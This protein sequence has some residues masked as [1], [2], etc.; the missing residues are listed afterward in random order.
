MLPKFISA[1]LLLV[2]LFG[3]SNYGISYS[4]VN[5]DSVNPKDFIR[6]SGTQLVVGND[7][8]PIV[9]QGVCFGN[10]VWSNPKQP[11]L[12]HHN[13]TDFNSVR[14]LRMNVIRFYLNYGLFEDDTRPFQYKKSGWDWLDRN[15][16][17]AKRNNVYL[18][19]N[20]H[21]PQGGYQ[22][23]GAGAALWD[24]PRNQRRLIALWKAIAKHCQAETIVAG[25][26]LV[27]EPITTRSIGQWQ[28]LAQQLVD[29]IRTVDQNHLLIVERLNAIK[30][31]WGN[32]A[33]YNF[34]LVND[35]NVM[36]TFHF[37]SPIEYTHQLTGWTGFGNQDGGTY[38]DESKYAFP[39]DLTWANATLSNPIAPAGKFNWTFFNG[40]HTPFQVT[41]P[42]IRCA[43]PAFQS[44]KNTGTIYFANFTVKEFD[45]SGNF[46]RYVYQD[47]A[48]NDWNG[49]FWSRNNSGTVRFVPGTGVNERN[50]IAISRT[51]DDANYSLNNLRFPVKTGYYY[52]ISG[53]MKGVDVSADSQCRLRLDFEVS[54]SGGSVFRR[55]KEYLAN[56][57]QHYIDW[58][59]AHRVPL[60]VGEFGAYYVC[61]Q[62]NKGGLQ[63]ISD[64]LDL[65]KANC[66]SYTYHAYHESG[67]G[68]YRNDIGLPDP[69]NVNQPLL[70]LFQNKLAN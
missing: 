14:N 8:H 39:T 58:G 35:L 67:F 33:N 34:C 57:L 66:L 41:D 68:L 6:A 53:W 5:A 48:F 10:Q 28:E 50:S 30:S 16:A 65:Y 45:A 25:Y 69:A 32:D 2:Y 15:I 7:D 42:K 47:E 54:P 55:D 46:V 62:N 21:Y 60:F 63:W 40:E 12:Y 23:N 24:D 43:K 22:S 36:Y 18:I 29:Q 52:S 19:L 27:N 17:W 3:F 44:S 38:P 56:E 64:L 13:E 37:Y 9:L 1:L 49:Y 61:F 11:V 51:G 70:D 31:N 4:L 59:A 20:M 26:D